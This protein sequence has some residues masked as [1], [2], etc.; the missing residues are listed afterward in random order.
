M[1]GTVAEIEGRPSAW[2]RAHAAVL[3]SGSG[4]VAG[5]AVWTLTIRIGQVGLEFLTGLI[6]ARLLGASSYGAYAFALSWAGLL[7]IPAAAG[8]DRL[9][10]REIAILRARSDWP[11]L[12]GILVR[13]NQ[14]A[15]FVSILFA[16]VA[17]GCAQILVGRIGAE[18]TAA[19]QLAM[20]MVPLVA[21]ARLRQ[22]ALQGFGRV[23][24]GQVPEMLLQPAVLLVLIAGLYALPAVPRTGPVAVGLHAT[25]ATAAC[26]AGIWL[27]RRALPSELT[28]AGVTYRTRT[29]LVQAM[30]FVW[31]LGMNVIMLHTD[32]ILLGLLDGS[33]AAGIYRAANQMA[34]FVAFPLTAVSMALAPAIARLYAQNDRAALQRSATRAAH[35]I[36]LMALPVASVLFLFGESILTVFGDRF[37]AGSTALAILSVGFLLNAAMG[38]SGYLLIMTKHEKAAAVAFAASAGLNLVGNLVLI[39]LFG[40][41]GAAAATALSVIVV[42]IAFAWLVYRK[43]GIQPTS[44]LVF[45]TRQ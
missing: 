13:S 22:A 20:V 2:R 39:P 35:A 19:L 25:A 38:V 9:L 1:N 10:I 21:I 28:A 23:A 14:I 27:L 32:V 29:W 34:S 37:A 17:A 31:I 5:N 16:V 33:E 3:P 15:V 45:T 30:P 11:A 42:S 43:L 40:V 24:L 8:F 26:I 44:F 6:A 4:Q 12:R 18:M 7:G 41:D 36:L